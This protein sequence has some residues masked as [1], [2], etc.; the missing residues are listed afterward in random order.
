MAHL[1]F[2]LAVKLYI[3]FIC[4]YYIYFFYYS[5]VHPARQWLGEGEKVFQLKEI[6]KK[7]VRYFLLDKYFYRIFNCLMNEDCSLDRFLK[8]EKKQKNY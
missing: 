6:Y 2:T 4:C 1:S 5:A 7:N 8:E 3:F